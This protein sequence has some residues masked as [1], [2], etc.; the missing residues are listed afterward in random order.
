[1]K[2]WVTEHSSAY[3]TEG[4]LLT[5]CRCL[6]TVLGDRFDYYFYLTRLLFYYYEIPLLILQMRNWSGKRWSWSKTIKLVNNKSEIWSQDSWP[7]LYTL[8]TTLVIIPFSILFRMLEIQHYF[9]KLEIKNTYRTYNCKEMNTHTGFYIAQ[10]GSK[11][12]KRFL[13]MFWK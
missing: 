5:A 13:G 7:R 3:Y 2:K 10:T 6:K 4:T 1:M 9:C 8:I 11:D 12:A